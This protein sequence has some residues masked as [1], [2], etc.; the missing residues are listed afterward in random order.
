M[1]APL[2]PLLLPTP[3]LLMGC[4]F[5]HIYNC[6][7]AQRSLPLPDSVKDLGCENLQGEQKPTVNR[8]GCRLDTGAKPW[9]RNNVRLSK[10]K[11]LI[12]W[13][14]DSAYHGLTILVL[15][16]SQAHWFVKPFFPS[17]L[18]C[19]LMS[20]WL[21][22]TLRRSVSPRSRRSPPHVMALMLVLGIG[23]TQCNCKLAK[24]QTRVLHFI[25]RSVYLLDVSTVFLRSLF[26]ENWF[27][28][29]E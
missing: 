20:R 5:N 14:S 13:P 8:L 28:A 19:K 23:S 16:V 6:S 21:D 3:H 18:S 7:D 29:F 17:L 4:S 1:L 12:P 15:Q 9:G 22:S 10:Q 25:D 24:L 27:S 11:T 2:L 26:L